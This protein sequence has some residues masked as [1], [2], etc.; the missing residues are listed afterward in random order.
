MPFK[1]SDS[2]ISRLDFGAREDCEFRLQFGAL[3]LI[4]IT[5]RAW[6]LRLKTEDLGEKI[7][8]EALVLWAGKI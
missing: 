8:L 1:G 4:N 6:D 2:R 7:Q 5:P 3:G